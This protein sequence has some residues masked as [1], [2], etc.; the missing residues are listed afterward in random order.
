MMLL[1]VVAVILLALIN[2]SVQ[3]QEQR[4]NSSCPIGAQPYDR[5]KNKEAYI[6]YIRYILQW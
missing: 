6:V 2:S 4:Q 5:V 1:A 3:H